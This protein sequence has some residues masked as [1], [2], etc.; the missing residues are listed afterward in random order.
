[1]LR[2]VRSVIGLA[3]RCATAR[4]DRRACAIAVGE[5]PRD[6]RRDCTCKSCASFATDYGGM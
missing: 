4:K 5:L 6:T 1:M 3:V 2:T